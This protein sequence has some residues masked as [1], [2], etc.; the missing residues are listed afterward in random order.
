MREPEKSY[1]IRQ[2]EYDLERG[3]YDP[4]KDV[5]SRY[6]SEPI[7]RGN[8]YNACVGCGL[9]E[10]AINGRLSGHGAHCSEVE[11]AANEHAL[12]DVRRQVLELIEQLPEDL[13]E[14][15]LDEVDRLCGCDKY[16]DEYMHPTRAMQEMNILF[17]LLKEAVEASPAG[18]KM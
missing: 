12:Y 15:F 18:P 6:D 2:V 16:D 13:G 11:R 10:P 3:Y 1:W 14:S 9:A 8:P 5:Y 7:G 4:E 17:M